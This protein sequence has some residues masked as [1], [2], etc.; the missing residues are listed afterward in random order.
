MERTLEDEMEATVFIRGLY[1]DV[2]PK[3]ENRMKQNME[4]DMETGNNDVPLMPALSDG[5]DSLAFTQDSRTCE[6]F[7]KFGRIPALLLGFKK[8]S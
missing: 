1:R 3:T 2:Y 4:N 5:R 7:V 8:N 6:L